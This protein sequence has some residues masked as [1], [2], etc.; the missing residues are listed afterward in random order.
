MAKVHRTIQRI[1]PLTL[2]L[3]IWCE[4]KRNKLVYQCVTKGYKIC[5]L[6][7]G[8]VYVQNLRYLIA[9][10]RIIL[11]FVSFL[12]YTDC[13]YFLTR[14]LNRKL[15]VSLLHFRSDEFQ[16]VHEQSNSN[17]CSASVFM[18]GIYFQTLVPH[19]LITNFE[20]CLFYLTCPHIQNTNYSI[21][22]TKFLIVEKY[23]WNWY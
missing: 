19:L 18:S 6:S 8:C 14:T 7:L 12:S 5:L 13:N 3:F 16:L 11:Y 2:I 10:S 20:C 9:Y 1:L 23:F 22:N 15:I 21:T 4:F 17:K